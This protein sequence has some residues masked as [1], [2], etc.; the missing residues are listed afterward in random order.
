MAYTSWLGVAGLFQIPYMGYLYPVLV[1]LL[2]VHLL[3]LWKQSRKVGYGPLIMSLTGASA[4]LLVR[5]YAPQMHW[6]LNTGILLMLAG[7][8]WHGVAMRVQRD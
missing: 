4:L 5:L 6:A 7:S 2:A 8:V 1:V 3:L